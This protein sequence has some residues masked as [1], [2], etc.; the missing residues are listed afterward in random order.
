V[1]IATHTYY[2]INR[3]GVDPK[4]CTR[5]HHESYIYI[6][7]IGDRERA[8]LV[9]RMCSRELDTDAFFI[10]IFLEVNRKSNTYQTPKFSAITYFLHFLFISVVYFLNYF[11]IKR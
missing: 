3:Y 9:T 7:E 8:W 6:P 4:Y 5:H 2:A 1:H 11:L 10:I